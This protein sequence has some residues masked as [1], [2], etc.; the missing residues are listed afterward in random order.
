MVADNAG[1][2]SAQSLKLYVVQLSLEHD[3]QIN[4]A[5]AEFKVAADERAV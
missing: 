2:H 4:V 3:D 1:V 5:Y